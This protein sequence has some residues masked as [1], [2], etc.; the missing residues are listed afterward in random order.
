M[1]ETTD[2]PNQQDENLHAFLRYLPKRIAAFEKRILRYRFEGWDRAGMLVLSSDVRRLAEASGHY[3]L[4]DTREHLLTL[5][6]MVGEHYENMHAPDPH[7]AERMFKLL[8]AVIKSAP[9]CSESVSHAAS[10]ETAAETDVQRAVSDPLT[11]DSMPPLVLEAITPATATSMDTVEPVEPAVLVETAEP[12]APVELAT[13]VEPITL[14]ELAAL[15]EP[16]ES[17]ELATLVEPVEPIALVEPIE[18]FE[19]GSIEPASVAEPGEP[20]ESVEAV[21]LAAPIEPVEPEEPDEADEP[22]AASEVG[23]RRL[24]HLNDGNTFAIELEQRL[25]SEG[26]AI[27]PVADT[28][29]LSELL[30]CLMP[31]LL[32]VDASHLPHLTAIGA[33][34]RDAQQRSQPHRRIQLV[35]MAVQDN[36]ETR[37]AAHRAGADLL[38]FPPFDVTDVSRRLRALHSAIAAD[39]VRVLIVEDNRADALYAQTVLTRAGMQ[40][41][42]EHDPMQVLE[43]LKSQIPDLV[44]MDLHM[45]FANGVEVT[46]LIREDPLFARL[47]IVFLSGESDPDSRLEA[48]NAGGDDFLFKPI[49]PKHLIAA[50]QERVRRMHPVNKQGLVA[51]GSDDLSG[52]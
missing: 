42:V 31:Q 5:A 46:L 10:S 30:M 15:I 26:Y 14:V 27:E 35:V 38:L 8:S 1:T 28:D 29:E 4:I 6:H 17:V 24:Y 12:V 39:K 16:A 23:M 49:R 47:P 48:I 33:L 43:S 36:M 21:E 7:Q 41:Q 45:P 52:A 37:R 34:R 20:V 51:G 11:A 9:S 3:E 22:D 2:H 44:L 32:L 40:A 13:L 19:P 50:V 18:T 25:E